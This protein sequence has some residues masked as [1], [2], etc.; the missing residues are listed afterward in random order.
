MD[1]IGLNRLHALR[2]LPVLVLAAALLGAGPS[3]ALGGDLD[4]E[5]AQ[6]ARERGEILPL[7][8]ILALVRARVGGDV[9]KVELERD[10]GI[11][12]YEL[13]VIDARNRL[14]EIEV[15]ARSGDILE[16]EE[17]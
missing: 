13:K 3:P 14:L 12:I 17:D 15:D 11:W 4:H 1:M 5:R 8:H 16:I 7:D 6:R 2:C 10:D 9:V